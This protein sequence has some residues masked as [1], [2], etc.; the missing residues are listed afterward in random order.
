VPFEFRAIG[1]E[2]AP[3]SPVDS[4]AIIKLVNSGQQWASK[5]KFGQVAA[6]LGPEAVLPLIPDVP[7]GSALIVPAGA[8]WTE[9]EHPFAQDI[10]RAMG[11]PDGPVGGGGGSN[12]WVIHGSR[13]ASG[14]P[15][16]AGDPHLQMTL[17]GQWY[18]VH[19]ECPQLV[20]AG[21]CNPGYPGPVFYGHNT[22]VA[23][24]MT[25][26]QGD[27]WD[28][29]RERIRQGADG[30]EVLYKGAWSPLAMVP[31]RF[32]VKG[33]EPVEGRT[34]LTRHG[35][36]VF[37]DPLTDS[38]VI[39]ARWGLAEAAHDT[40]AMLAV[41]HCSTAEE[42]A[43]GFR[44]YDSVSGNFCFADAAGEI[45]YQYSGRIPR[46][47]AWLVPVPGWDGAHEWDGDVPK[48]EL[49]AERNPGSG[50]VLTANNRTTS[51]DYPHYLTYV[52]TRFRAD[53]LRELIDE[54]VTLDI[55]DMRR[56]QGDQESIA[57]RDLAR[58][59]A[60]AAPGTAGGERLR[61]LFAGWNGRL[62]GGS[63]AALAYDAVC[64]ALAERTLRP[65]YAQGG[66]SIPLT[67]FDE[68][69]IVYEQAVAR[70]PLMLVRDGSWEAAIANAM[71]EAA[72]RLE[73]RFGGDTAA[74][75]WDAAHEVRWRHNLG[76]S[77][78]LA[79]LLN[80]PPVPVGGDAT[81]PFNSAAERDGSVAIGVSYRQ[82]LDMADL[83]GARICIPPGNSGQP[84][85]PH[86]A[87]NV[88]RWRNVEY[89]PLFIEWPDIEA[90]GEARLR[91]D[92]SPARDPK[93]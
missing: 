91:L 56:F 77:G 52:T 72:T 19:M 45:G 3:W 31:E 51:P 65:F 23:W 32:T 2:M 80:L 6:K 9:E 43:A 8:R 76:R 10:A 90:N 92:P 36:V 63:P 14:K 47:P 73:E 15:L 64:E 37:G 28:L 21:P 68:R 1:H 33:E 38:E 35:P 69:R 39:V 66:L 34:W 79:S 29:Y 49:P 78:E 84:G 54:R 70:S 59:F 87:D 26:A 55:A 7:A 50:Y 67:L 89:H 5:L 85:S 88:E 40:D 60:E 17:P 20:A 81:T 62:D 58:Q 16:V 4:L 41:L 74:W 44:R 75:R 11:E 27:R 25:H 83:N 71:G 57:A 18:V 93:G 30:P 46:R 48:E 12:C 42:A 82:V 86:Y 61:T 22:K 24:T 13:T 53:R